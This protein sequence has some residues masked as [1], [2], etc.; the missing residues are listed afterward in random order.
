MSDD[1]T[2]RLGLPYL[3]AGQMQKHVTLNEALTRLDAL[4]QTAVVSCTEPAQPADPSDGALYI[5][6]A[7]ATGSEWTGRAAGTLI[8]AET[9]GWSAVEAPDGLVVLVVDAGE[10]LVRHGG[11]WVSLGA[12]L[13]AVQ[14]LSRLGLGTTADPAN[15]FAAR[16]NNALWTARATG[17]G[18]DGDLRLTLNKEGAA[19]V[20]SLLFQSGYGGRAELGLIGDDD[21]R[22]KVS[23]DGST[24]RDAWSVDRASGQVSFDLGATRRAVTVMTS[25]GSYPVPAWARTIEAVAV[26]AGAGGGAGASGASGSRF[27]GGGGGAGGIGRAI[28]PAEQL[29]AS[30]TVVVGSGGAGGVAAAGSAGSGSAVYLGS[31]PLL[32]ATGG[33]G[34]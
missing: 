4:V 8:R 10:L 6:P 27:G 16:L 26:G 22:L 24:W 9:G 21:L 30:L 5:L 3:A 2:A 29:T 31:T 33:G 20:L 11:A 14:N 1:Q 18:G 7:E 23:S 34:G 13:E 17:E 32:V 25:G 12:R 19:D 28:W 15:P